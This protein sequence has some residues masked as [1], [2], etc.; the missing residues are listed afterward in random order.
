MKAHRPG[1]EFEA[2]TATCRSDL[3]A[4]R[5][6]LLCSVNE[7]ALCYAPQGM[8]GMSYRTGRCGMV[9][10][11]SD[12]CVEAWAT[13]LSTRNPNQEIQNWNWQS[14]HGNTR[15]HSPYYLAK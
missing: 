4:K 12:E 10:L 2:A 7:L 1:V 5:L 14:R 11:P 6:T 3:W 15:W 13:V 8:G 9:Y